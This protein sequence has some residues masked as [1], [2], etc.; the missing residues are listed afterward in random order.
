MKAFYFS[1][2]L[3]LK[4]KDDCAFEC[5]HSEAHEKI[6]FL[7]GY[8]RNMII[9]CGLDNFSEH[10]FFPIQDAHILV[11]D[12]DQYVKT[13]LYAVDALRSLTDRVATSYI[14]LKGVGFT[15]R[16]AIDTLKVLELA[17]NQFGV[18]EYEKYMLV[19]ASN[20]SVTRV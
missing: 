11:S 3:F 20:T 5:E 14:T 8:L 2:H 4:T 6:K 7:E 16:D 9:N 10:L 1:G 19:S 12:P 18:V 15:M 13:R 17:G